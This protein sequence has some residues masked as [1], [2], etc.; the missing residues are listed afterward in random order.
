M[1]AEEGYLKVAG[2]PGQKK[3][4]QEETAGEANGEANDSADSGKD[5]PAA[6]FAAVKSLKK[7]MTLPVSSLDIKEGKTSP[8]KRYN[9]GSLILAMENAGQLIEDEELREQIKSCGIGTSAS[10]RRDETVKT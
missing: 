8:P 4:K 10:E 9:S 7:G 5:D 3:G 1:L 6:L 2:I